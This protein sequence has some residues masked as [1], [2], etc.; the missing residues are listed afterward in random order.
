MAAAMPEGTVLPEGWALHTDEQGQTFYWNQ[1][2]S[3][4]QWTPPEV[5]PELVN[6]FTKPTEGFMC[7]EDAN[8]YDIKFTGFKIR[9]CDEGAERVICS[10][11]EAHQHERGELDAM[12]GKTVVS[13]G[14]HR[15]IRY[16]FG[17]EF[18]EF[19]TIGT[20]LDFSNGSQPLTNFRMIERHFFREQL[21]VNYDFEM[22]FVIPGTTNTW[23]MIY[24]KPELS[25]EWKSVLTTCPWETKSDSFYFVN[26]QLVMHNRAEYNYCPR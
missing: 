7:A 9:C 8:Q 24:T 5:T 10:L 14:S 6:S 20:T 21:I 19:S 3:E 23:E 4:T 2:T 22:P 13:D 18:L 25:D 16:H 17:P 11:G 26:G 1:V 15:W 12:D